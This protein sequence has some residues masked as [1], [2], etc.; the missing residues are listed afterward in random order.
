MFATAKMR[1][2]RAYAMLV[3][4]M[5][6]WAGNSIIGRA[7]HGDIGP[8]TLAFARWSGACVVL[9][10]FALG[11]LRRDW[12]AIRRG[13]KWLVLLGLLGV[14]AYNTLLYAGLR[15]TTASNALLLQAAIP[16]IILL[17]NRMLFDVRST[18]WQVVGIFASSF[19]VVVIVFEGSAASALKL[20]VG[21]GEELVLL[22][23]FSWAL[24]TV[25]L[26]RR[27]EISA[28]S[29]IVCTFL[30]GVAVLAPLAAWER[31][32]GAAT[33]WNAE[34]LGAVLY[35]SLLASL[36]AFFSY[37]HAASEI[38]PTRAGQALTL[39][40]LFGALLAVGLLGETLHSFHLAGMV[41][42]LAGTAVAGLAGRPHKAISPDLPAPGS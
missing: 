24:Y 28:V 13:W 17:L 31:H 32:F 7:V 29:L 33:D 6:L 23:V 38:G 30:V 42:I 20:N 5:L 27:P 41:M 11:S 21:T 8:F 10:P 12:P 9:L 39:M 34:L 37:N 18:F 16:A 19:G 2:L 3:L 40:P 15:Y 14:A 35:V 26:R 25:L 36:V 1:G 4:A 22:A